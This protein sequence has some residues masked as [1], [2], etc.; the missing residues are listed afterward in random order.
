MRILESFRPAGRLPRVL[1][2]AVGVGALVGLLVVGFEQIV[3]FMLDALFE[4]PLWGQTL[5]PAAGLAGAWVLLRFVGGRGATPS[6]SDEY[7]RAFHERSP[8]MP[9]RHLPAKLLAGISTIGLGGALGLEGP[10]VYAGASA[11]HNA[12]RALGRFFRRDEAKMLLTAG[13]AAGVAA[14]FRTPATGVI[15]AL[16]VPYRDDVTR[17]ALLPSLVASAVS[18]L[19]F[20]AVLG[21]T[22]PVFPNL[23]AEAASLATVDLLGGALLGLVAGLGGRGFAA[24]VRRAKDVSSA[25]GPVAR[26]AGAGVILAGLVVATNAVFGEPLS[27][28]PGLR[29][30]DWLLA[31]EHS[32]VLIAALFG[33]R[34]LA[35]LVSVGAGGT[36]GLFFPLAVQGLL[37]GTVVGQVLGQGETSLYPTLGLSAFLAAG[38][39]APIAAVMFVAESSRGSSFVAPALIAAAV[40]QLV[41][42]KA[43]VSSHQASERQGHLER[44]FTLPIASVLQTDVMTV[45][46]DA[47]ISEFMTFHVQGRRER[48]VAV[49]EG[50]RYLGMCGLDQL[51]DLSRDDWD[52]R[53]VGE[54]LESGLP[55]A[56]PSW[57]LR[58]AVAA[59]ETA[60]VTTLA[61]VTAEE[62]FVGIVTAEDILKLDEILDETES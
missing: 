56:R 17:R 43:G 35:T 19:V 53:T 30:A 20:V 15:F 54:M 29:S 25:V 39:R 62:T 42:G 7:I 9:V 55:S 51:G 33:F 22:T 14:I 61:V 8:R 40:A 34:M 60:D 38:Y 2:A 11:A 26:L 6:T 12:Q 49:V 44:R 50:G 21:E 3:E 23:G 28:G 36:G 4:M 1:G 48:E 10:S 5:A 13:A 59:M 46:P 24:L 45:P 37:M 32:L 41:A 27:L 58:D 16:E 47:T 52:A 18:Y 57:T 31:G